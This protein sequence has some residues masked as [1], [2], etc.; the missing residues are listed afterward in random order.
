MQKTQFLAV[1]LFEFLCKIENLVKIVHI[2]YKFSYVENFSKNSPNSSCTFLPEWFT[3]FPFPRNGAQTARFMEHRQLN[4]QNTSS[5]NNR[6]DKRA[7]AGDDMLGRKSSDFPERGR[8]PYG[9]ATGKA[10]GYDSV[11]TYNE[12]QSS[13]PPRKRGRAAW[14]C[15]QWRPQRQASAGFAEPGSRCSRPTGDVQKCGGTNS[16]TRLFK[17]LFTY[18]TYLWRGM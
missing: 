14:G 5:V 10:A 18:F 7:P 3:I 1:R 2:C 16:L 15:K 8:P 17:R 6:P 12:T 4:Q 13:W 11:G 9:A